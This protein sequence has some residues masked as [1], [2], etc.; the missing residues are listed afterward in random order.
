MDEDLNEV[1][2]VDADAFTKIIL[3]GVTK[4]EIQKQQFLINAQFTGC[5][6]KLLF[7]SSASLTAISVFLGALIIALELRFPDSDASFALQIV[8][9]AILAISLLY[10][11]IIGNCNYN[12]DSAVS[13]ATVKALDTLIDEF[14]VDQSKFNENSTDPEWRREHLKL[15][16]QMKANIMA[17]TPPISP[18]LNCWPGFNINPEPIYQEFADNMNYPVE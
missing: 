18:C 5:I 10:K 3:K 6:H 2:F 11:L 14:A 8:L 17:P 7:M 4:A 13:G 12:V 15:Y 16:N 9:E 1:D